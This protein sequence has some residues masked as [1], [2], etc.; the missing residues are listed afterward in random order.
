MT[1]NFVNPLFLHPRRNQPAG[2]TGLRSAIGAYAT[3]QQDAP[4][5]APRSKQRATAPAP[6]PRSSSSL[7][8]LREV[9]IALQEIQWPSGFEKH[10]ATSTREK[11]EQLQQQARWDRAIAFVLGAVTVAVISVW[12][13]TR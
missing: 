13:F 11:Q 8:S 6:A 7:R 4:A 5:P 3:M 10:G 9:E 12:I 1:H 2:L